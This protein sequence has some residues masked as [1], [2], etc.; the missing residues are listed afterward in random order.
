MRV[1]AKAQRSD[2]W[3]AVEVPEVPGVFTQARRLDQ[4]PDMVADAVELVAG[5]AKADIVVD[6][7]PITDM[8]D[9]V[10]EAREARQAAD[11]AGTRASA[12]MRF[13]L[14]NLIQAGY[15]VRDAGQLLGVSPQRVSQLMASNERADSSRAKVSTAS[16]N[17]KRRF[18]DDRAAALGDATATRTA[19][20]AA[21]RSAVTGRKI[22]PS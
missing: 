10:A 6:V 16:A 1:T 4:I 2:G 8:D 20:K 11:E 17:A 9:V 22:M 3:W 13:A 19:A 18:A 14:S 5:V 15:T 21:A 7:E 12:T